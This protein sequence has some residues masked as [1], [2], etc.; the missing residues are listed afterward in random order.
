MLKLE[1]ISPFEKV[2]STEAKQVILPT[3]MGEVGLLK[4]HIPLMTQLK[5]GV[6][7]VFGSGGEVSYA[8]KGGYAQLVANTVSVLTDEA[9]AS[10][11]INASDLQTQISA[12]E[13]KLVDLESEAKATG[14]KEDASV[15]QQERIREAL[16]FCQLQ[17]SL[18]NQR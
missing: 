17:A 3:E 7:K 10:S 1:I 9:R 15:H 13:K 18:L 16:R 8:I 2:L 14:T 12:L 4:G 6:L 11:D 5:L